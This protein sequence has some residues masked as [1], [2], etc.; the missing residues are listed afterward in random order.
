MLAFPTEVKVIVGENFSELYARTSPKHESQKCV[1]YHGI[2]RDVT[3]A[4]DPSI[5]KL[6]FF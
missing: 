5:R 6:F 3:D 2:Q 1:F 4:P